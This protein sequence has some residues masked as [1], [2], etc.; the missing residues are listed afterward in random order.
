MKKFILLVIVLVLCAIVYFALV[1]ETKVYRNDLLQFSYP[2]ELTLWENDNRVTLYHQI[3]YKNNGGCDMAGEDKIYNNLTDFQ[4]SFEVA[5]LFKKPQVVDGQYSAG[6]LKGVYE[7]EGAEGCGDTVYYFP[8]SSN[9]QLI[10]RRANIQAL[11]GVRNNM[12]ER[13]EILLINGV[14]NKDKNEEIFKQIL[15][16]VKINK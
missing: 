9:N 8:I 16:S 4:V 15:S 5:S 2:K 11:S 7:Y 3:P 1:S 6:D 10:V 13:E 14:I 12:E